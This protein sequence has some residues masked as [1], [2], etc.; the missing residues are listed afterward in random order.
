VDVVTV[1]GLADVAGLGDEREQLVGDV[2][3][4][5]AVNTAEGYAGLG[6]SLELV[7]D[8][9]LA[10]L[11]ELHVPLGLGRP[12]FGPLAGHGAQI[13]WLKTKSGGI[14][15]AALLCRVTKDPVS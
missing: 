13:R 1:L 5:V 10:V 4:G 14:S 6:P 12:P 11:R 2:R 8:V 9:S 3:R 7:I 15:A